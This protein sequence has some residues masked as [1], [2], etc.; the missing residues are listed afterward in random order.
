[1]S[2]YYTKY[3]NRVPVAHLGTTIPTFPNLFMVFGP[4]VA[5]GH[6]SI[7]FVIET[8]VNLIMQLIKPILHREIA[9]ITIKRDACD[10]YNER[11]QRRLGKTTFTQCMSY[12]RFGMSGTNFVIFPGPVGLLWWWSRKPDWSRYELV[13]GEAW[14]RARRR[15]KLVRSVLCLVG[16]LIFVAVTCHPDLLKWVPYLQTMALV[17]SID[18]AHL[19]VN[20]QWERLR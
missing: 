1:M 11:I 7:L 18:S 2:E 9:A 5:S 3:H 8:Q 19:W 20:G 10:A 6:A 16:L 13:D 17:Q 14:S 12:Y 15:R 4:N